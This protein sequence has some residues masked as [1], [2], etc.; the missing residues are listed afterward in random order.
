V[1]RYLEI[2]R[3]AEKEAQGYDINDIN[4]KRVAEPARKVPGYGFGRFGRTLSALEARCPDR[5]PIDRWQQAVADGR[6]FLAHWADQAHALGWT[7]KDL[8]GLLPV[9]EHAKPSF[10]RLARYDEI[11]LIWLLRG[12]G[13]AALTEATAAIRNPTGSITVYRRHKKPALGPV[14]DSLAN[15][16]E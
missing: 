10:S 7:A 6:T 11:G 16:T 13:V 8:F 2:L 4:D 3:R 12:R 5:V 1:G 9:P 15:L 14:G